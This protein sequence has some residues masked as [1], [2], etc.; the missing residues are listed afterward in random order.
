MNHTIP[1][2][3]MTE[4]QIKKN[5]WISKLAGFS[6][7]C[8]FYLILKIFHHCE[9][10]KRIYHRIMVALSFNSI[11]F[12]GAVFCNSWPIPR[13]Y[14]IYGAAGT[15]GM[16]NTQGAIFIFTYFTICSYYLLLSVFALFSVR[17]NFD[18]TWFLKFEVRMHTSM[19]ILP[20]IIV[21]VVLKNESVNPGI[22]NQCMLATYPL[23]CSLGDQYGKCVRGESGY[24]IISAILFLLASTM[25]IVA[26]VL[27]SVL[28]ISVRR[29]ENR[30]AKLMGEKKLKENARKKKSRIIVKQASIYCLT[31]VVTFIT[32]TI[33]RVLVFFGGGQKNTAALVF[34]S[35]F[36]LSLNGCINLMVYLLLLKR[37][38]DNLSLPASESIPD[39]ELSSPSKNK[40]FVGPEFSI[41]DGSNSSS[42][43]KRFID[44]YTDDNYDDN[45]FEVQVP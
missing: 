30:N 18:E 8:S 45:G 23:K 27:F 9:R 16:C 43:W 2:I 21:A 42:R 41:F 15:Q 44:E 7:L 12:C 26:V 33:C 3:E 34:V 28:A 17:N 40:C 39:Q 20:T 14:S 22:I 6:I 29:K 35:T 13:S 11:L 5:F 24:S 32:P 36:C 38:P 1:F 25:L 4:S 19:Y 37:K 10:R 31:Y